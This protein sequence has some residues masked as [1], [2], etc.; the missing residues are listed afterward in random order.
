MS[1][2]PKADRKKQELIT[3]GYDLF[4]SEGHHVKYS[5]FDKDNQKINELGIPLRGPVMIHDI[6]IT[7]KNVIIPDL[8]MQFKPEN[9]ALG[10]NAFEFNRNMSAKYGIMDRHCTDANEIKWFDLPNHF[11]F[12]YINA[13]DSV[14]DLG[15]DIVTLFGCSLDD[16]NLEHK[17]KENPHDPSEQER[18]FLWEA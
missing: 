3:F 10:N 15:E 7:E 12:H 17:H 11:V 13:W 14:N 6:A 5:L 16:I 2:H 9:C 8:P 4:G 18:P 1:A